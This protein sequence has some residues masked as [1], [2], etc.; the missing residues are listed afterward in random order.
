M[1]IEPEDYNKK[2]KFHLFVGIEV[3]SYDFFPLEFYS[4]ILPKTEYLFFTSGYKGEGTESIFIDWL[5]KSKYE[6]SYPYIMQSYSPKRWKGI[7][8]PESLMDWYIP[9]KEKK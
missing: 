9:I 8:N 4:K 3:S 5:P 7:K 6:Q 2:R 1:H